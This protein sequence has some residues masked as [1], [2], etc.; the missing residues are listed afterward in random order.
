MPLSYLFV[1]GFIVR[2]VLEQQFTFGDLVGVSEIEPQ[3]M[4]RFNDLTLQ[5]VMHV[6]DEIQQRCG[7]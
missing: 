3:L 7:H 6:Q 1:V 2:I 5:V 4:S